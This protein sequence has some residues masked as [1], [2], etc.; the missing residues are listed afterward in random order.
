MSNSKMESAINQNTSRWFGRISLPVA[1]S[2]PS[3]KRGKMQLLPFSARFED[4]VGNTLV[5]LCD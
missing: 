2:E 1:L 5:N 3:R 4:L